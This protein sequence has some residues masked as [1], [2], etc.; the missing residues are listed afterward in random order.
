MMVMQLV[1]LVV[2]LEDM[3][4]RTT[5]LQ[6]PTTLEGLPVCMIDE[7]GPGCVDEDLAKNNRGPMRKRSSGRR[8][9]KPPRGGPGTGRGW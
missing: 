8:S 5:R 4:M 3:A 2:V 7:R 6:V 9:Q 1:V